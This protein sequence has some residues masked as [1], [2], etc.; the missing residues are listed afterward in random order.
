VHSSYNCFARIDLTS[1]SLPHDVIQKLQTEDDLLAILSVESFLVEVESF[2]VEVE[3]CLVEVE[4]LVQLS[5]WT[6]W[7][8]SHL[9][10]VASG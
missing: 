4:C 6:E 3:S 5:C 9:P 7:L 8:V 1:S 2:L 10:S